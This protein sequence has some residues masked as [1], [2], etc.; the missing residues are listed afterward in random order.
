MYVCIVDSVCIYYVLDNP[1]E[2]GCQLV[3]QGHSR[4]YMD[5]H[6]FV[7]LCMLNS[8]LV[9]HM[10]FRLCD[11]FRKIILCVV[12]GVAFDIIEQIH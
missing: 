3:L 5:G 4:P 11:S 2:P 6:H 10:C 8:E 7:K 1:L 9:S 12:V